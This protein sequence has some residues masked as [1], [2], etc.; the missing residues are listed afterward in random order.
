[1]TI[2]RCIPYAHELRHLD[3]RSNGINQLGLAS[4]A[5]ALQLSAAL[6]S[7]FVWGNGFGQEASHAFMQVLR[8]VAAEGRHCAST[9][10]HMR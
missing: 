9:S 3:L 1:M 2:S 8:H 7:L 4:L 5:E 10:L 6:Q